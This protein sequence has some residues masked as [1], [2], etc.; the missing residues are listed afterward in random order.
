MDRHFS[1]ILNLLKNGQKSDS[2]VAHSEQ[3]F[4]ST[5]SHTDLRKCMIPKLVI[6]SNS[7]DAMKNSQN[8]IVIYVWR[9]V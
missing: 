7:I 2:F 3:D 6:D 1:D 8:T 4:N 5:T 9:N